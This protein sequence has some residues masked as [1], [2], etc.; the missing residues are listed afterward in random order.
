MTRDKLV[1]EKFKKD[2]PI[3]KCG[4][5]NENKPV[6]VEIKIRENDHSKTP[7][8]SKICVKKAFGG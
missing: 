2:T 1:K 6:Y 3:K 5:C 4:A 7:L 8:C